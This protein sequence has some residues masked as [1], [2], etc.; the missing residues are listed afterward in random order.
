MSFYSMVGGGYCRNRFFE[1]QYNENVYPLYMLNLQLLHC[2]LRRIMVNTNL[3][4]VKLI[5]NL[6]YYKIGVH[7]YH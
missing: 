6:I 7:Q 5:N 4:F 2:T 3:L 1:L